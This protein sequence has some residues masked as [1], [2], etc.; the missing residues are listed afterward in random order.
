MLALFWCLHVSISCRIDEYD[1]AFQSLCL[2]LQ[3]CIEMITQILEQVGAASDFCSVQ[4][5][6]S[7]QQLQVA[8][9]GLENCMM[10]ICL[11]YKPVGGK[12]I[13]VLCARPKMEMEDMFKNSIPD[14]R[15]YKSTLIF[16]QVCISMLC[17]IPLQAKLMYPCSSATLVTDTDLMCQGSPLVPEDLKKVGADWASAAIVVADS[18]RFATWLPHYKYQCASALTSGF[19]VY[20][21]VD[22]CGHSSG[23]TV[24]S[25][26]LGMQVSRRGRCTVT[27]GGCA[28]G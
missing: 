23:H 15:R 4:G 22:L 1:L 20:E 16:R 11:A 13:A 9:L 14:R 3:R 17:N 5:T 7:S 24:K 28:P 25:L 21:L 2:L 18:S 26:H 27:E 10:Q 8:F 12:P 19:S 6:L